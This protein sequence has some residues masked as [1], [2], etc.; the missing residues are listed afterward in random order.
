MIYRTRIKENKWNNNLPIRACSSP[1]PP[2]ALPY[3][4]A[5]AA[6]Y[7]VRASCVFPTIND[8]IKNEYVYISGMHRGQ[9]NIG[10]E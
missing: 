6:F 8:T 4:I 5:S 2:S 10:Q 3:V 7:F 9:N 1:A